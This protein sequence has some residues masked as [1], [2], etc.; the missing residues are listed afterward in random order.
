MKYRLQAVVKGSVQGIGYRYFVQETARN[1]GVTG[2]VQNLPGG[3]VALEAEGTKEILS[4]F[5]R[6]IRENHREAVITEITHEFT[7][8]ASSP[9]PD[10]FIKH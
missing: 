10:F 4:Q 5:L 7:P 3:D 2:W 1:A 6:S 8:V 9:F